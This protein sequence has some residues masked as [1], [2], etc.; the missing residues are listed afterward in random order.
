M[1]KLKQIEVT[2]FSIVKKNNKSN[3]YMVNLNI[4]P[5]MLFS[6]TYDEGNQRV[7]NS[8]VMVIVVLSVIVILFY[9]VFQSLG[10]GKG[11]NNSVLPNIPTPGFLGGNSGGN[12]GGNLTKKG[13]N[14][15]EII[16]WGS[17]IFLVLINGLQYFFGMD[18]KTSIRNIFSRTPEVDV[19]IAPHGEEG[20]EVVPTVPAVPQVPKIPVEEWEE[21]EE[22]LVEEI[23]EGFCKDHPEI[24]ERVDCE[25]KGHTWIES[26]CRGDEDI[27]TRKKCEEMGYEWVVEQD[28]TG[29]DGRW[30]DNKGE[31]ED[32]GEG[33]GGGPRGPDS[34]NKPVQVD[35]E[36]YGDDSSPE[37]MIEKQVFHVPINKYTYKDARAL[38]GA[39]GGRLATYNEIEDAYNKGGEW[40]SYGW[41]KGQNIYY[42]TQKKTYKKLQKIKGHE[43]DCGRPGINGGYVANENAQFGVN[44]MAPKP[45]LSRMGQKYMESMNLYPQTQDEKDFKKQVMKYKNDLENILVSPFNKRQ[46]SQV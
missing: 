9:L 32:E 22:E 12:S 26:Y 42:P 16:M 19:S 40:C 35:G 5:S 28:T 23:E 44:C 38:C 10:T 11:G 34:N 33:Y 17:I 3:I 30:D 37:I 7:A 8:N 15:L 21:E 24:T 31:G 6:D 41:S 1:K 43:H 29:G 45:Q 18:I 36:G 4:S 46:W 27:K 39:F 13:L 14:I 20:E 25:E 2:A